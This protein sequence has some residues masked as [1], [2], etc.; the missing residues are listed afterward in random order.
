MTQ[1]TP[2]AKQ[3]LADEAMAI[4]WT[5]AMERLAHPEPG[6]TSW[7]ASVR[8]DSQPPAHA[9]SCGGRA[10]VARICTCPYRLHAKVTFAPYRAS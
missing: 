6:R 9:T 8:S 3:L 2:V 4:P 7:L 10:K 1:Q 5:T